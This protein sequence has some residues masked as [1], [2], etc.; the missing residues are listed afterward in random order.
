[1]HTVSARSQADIEAAVTPGDWGFACDSYGKVRHSKKACVY[2]SYGTPNGDRLETLAARVPNW[3]DARLF[4]A[5]KD[6]YMA[7]KC[8]NHVTEGYCICPLLDGSA[9]DEKHASS[10]VDARRAIR[11]IEG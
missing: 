3:T 4:A 10:C 11:R 6:M 9:P 7:L 2:S 1:M 5:A 8:I